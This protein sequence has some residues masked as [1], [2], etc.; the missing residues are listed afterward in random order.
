MKSKKEYNAEYYRKRRENGLCPRCGKPMDRNGY[1]CSKCLEKDRE[2]RRENR[3]FCRENKI[4]PVC[5]KEKLFGDEKQCASCRAYNYD[6]HRKNPVSKEKRRIYNATFRERQNKLYQ[7]RVANGICTRCG[8]FKAALGK[9]KCALC[10]E[11][12]E[13]VHRNRRAYEVELQQTE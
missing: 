12:D 3:K 11:K 2:Y 6:Y 4:C 7:K 13:V 1:L 8:K 5:Q 9:K 10:L